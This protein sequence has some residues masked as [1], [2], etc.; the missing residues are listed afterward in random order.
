MAEA[1][2]LVG[3][4][5]IHVAR[6]IP[7]PPGT[8]PGQ[9][10]AKDPTIARWCAQTAHVLVTTDG[11]FR[12]RW[13]RSKLLAQH[14]VEVIVF[15]KEI[16]GLAEQHRQ[17]TLHLPHWNSELGRHPYGYR[18]WLQRLNGK[19]PKLLEGRRSPA[20][21]RAPTSRPTRAQ[22]EH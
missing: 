6:A 21:S 10:P 17:V 8:V 12:G 4:D 18:V 3:H 19:P 1:L 20:D 22:R 16:V 5:V 11:D 13:V 14:G 2:A 7:P 9:Q 15:D